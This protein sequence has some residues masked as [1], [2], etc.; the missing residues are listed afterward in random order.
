[1]NWPTKIPAAVLIV[2]AGF[3]SISLPVQARPALKTYR[4]GVWTIHASYDT[5]TGLNLCRLSAKQ[6]KIEDDVAIFSLGRK[7]G[8]EDAVIRIDNGPVLYPSV[9]RA[10]ITSS[11]LYNRLGP[12]DDREDKNVKIPASLL[13]DANMVDIR[14]DLKSRV[15][16][17]KLDGLSSARAFMNSHSCQNL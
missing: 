8:L 17:Y 14:P 13:V 5:F 16:H 4:F 2:A 6:I 12:L 10:Q 1:M 15:Y 7:M 9:Y 3:I 11:T